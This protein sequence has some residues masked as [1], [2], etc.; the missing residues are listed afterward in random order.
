MTHHNVGVHRGAVLLSGGIDS[1]TVA[2]I[3]AQQC[4]SLVAIT[5]S[6]GQKHQ[7]AEINA[8]IEV[9]KELQVEDHILINMPDIFTGAG[10]ALMGEQDMPEKTYEEL[11][12]AEGPSPTVVPF[13]NAN[14]ISMATSVAISHGADCLYVGMHATDGHNFAYPDC[15]PEFLGSMA[16]AVFVGSYYAVRLFFPL[17]W[18]TKTD[19][20]RT[21]LELKVPVHKTYSCYMGGSKHCSTCPTCVERINAFKANNVIDPVLYDMTGMDWEDCAIWEQLPFAYFV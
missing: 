13:R 10:S 11:Q 6:Y 21:A 2:Y 17:I 9:A 16:N 3:A 8:A 19:V 18:M 15:T 1:A 4:H 7:E 20:V 5:A 12:E 14:L